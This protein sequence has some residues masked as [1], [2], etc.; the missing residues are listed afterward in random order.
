MNESDAWQVVQGRYIVARVGQARV[1]E[2][3]EFVARIELA[4]LSNQVID[5]AADAR[6]V[7]LNVPA[8]D[9]N[10]QGRSPG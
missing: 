10:A 4:K 3:H 6:E 8:V 5:V 2:H 7:I 9:D 1:V